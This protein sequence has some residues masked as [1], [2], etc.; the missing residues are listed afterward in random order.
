MINVKIPLQEI[1]ALSHTTVRAS[2]AGRTGNSLKTFNY[3]YL[4]KTGGK[5][6]NECQRSHFTSVKY[7]PKEGKSTPLPLFDWTKSFKNL[8]R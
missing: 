7:V 5:F 3:G 2:G 6:L 4:Y 1:Y 8:S